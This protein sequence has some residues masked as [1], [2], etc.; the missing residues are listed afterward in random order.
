MIHVVLF[1][2]ENPGNVGNIMRTCA[3]L[4][5]KLHMI[6]PFGFRLMDPQYKRAVMDYSQHVE[7]QD[8]PDWDTFRASVP[9][10]AKLYAFTTK[11]ER[12]YTHVEY[13]DGDHLVFGPESRGLPEWIRTEI[14]AVTIPMPGQ[15]R[16]LNL[17]VSVGIASFEVLRQLNNNWS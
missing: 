12:V 4:G 2:P 10:G 11:T 1:E 17:S 16:S 14:E 8:H 15:G 7:W 9:E 5:V 3:V 13:R 6:R